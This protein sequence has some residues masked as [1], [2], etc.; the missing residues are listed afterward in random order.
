VRKLIEIPMQ[1]P[2]ITIVADSK[3]NTKD[4]RAYL[5]ESGHSYMFKQDGKSDPIF[6]NAMERKLFPNETRYAWKSETKEIFCVSNRF[7]R[8]HYVGNCFKRVKFAKLRDTDPL[9][10]Y[11]N[12]Y[13]GMVDHFNQLFA[14][15]YWHRQHMNDSIYFFDVFWQFAVTNGFAVFQLLNPQNTETQAQF[16]SNLGLEMIEL[17]GE[18]LSE[19]V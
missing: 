17:N 15:H 16:L 13:C 18:C 10:K 3:F 8:G 9:P 7:Q 6:W 1:L 5:R 11:Y 14:E 12:Q 2:T 4:V 19:T